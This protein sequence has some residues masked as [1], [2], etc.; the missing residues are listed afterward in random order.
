MLPLSSVVLNGA[1]TTVER[2]VILPGPDD[3]VMDEATPGKGTT[4][5]GIRFL[6]GYQRAPAAWMNW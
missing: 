1:E 5:P 3:M 2:T 6:G 4:A